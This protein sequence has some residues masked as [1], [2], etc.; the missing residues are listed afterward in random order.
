MGMGYGPGTAGVNLSPK[1]VAKIQK[2]QAD[3]YA[4]IA[5]V[6]NEMFT[7]RTELQNLFRCRPSDRAWGQGP[8]LK[9]A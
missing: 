6:R 7:K 9:W 8:V 4:E 3:R 5:P 2:I 1:Q